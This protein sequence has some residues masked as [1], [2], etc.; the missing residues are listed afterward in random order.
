MQDGL[1]ITLALAGCTIGSLHSIAPDHW[2]PFAALARAQNWSAAKTARLTAL[3][4]FGHVSVS[5]LLGLLGL[6]F[7][8]QLLEAFGRRMESLA[9]LLLIGF[10]VAYA[11]WG[12]RR[13]AGPHLHEHGDG[14]WHAHRLGHHHHHHHH[15]AIDPSRRMSAW[16][17]FLIF[18]ADPCVAVIP[19]LFA[20]APLGAA[21]AAGIVLLYEGATIGT[22]VLLVLPA[23][24]GVERL[25]AKWVEQ[26]GDAAAGALIAFV[27]VSVAVLGW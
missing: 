6:A 25:R 12:L 20:A 27:G 22:M 11:I 5:V 9:G 13:V 8:V 1:F 16:T 2:V 14:T 19:L 18:C 4:G 10:G 24:A 26:Y 21:Q 3:C 7:G 23:R 17:L 15:H